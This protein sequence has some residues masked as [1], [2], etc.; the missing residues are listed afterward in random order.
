MQSIHGKKL[1]RELVK[2]MSVLGH[3]MLTSVCMYTMCSQQ[4]LL[5]GICLLPVMTLNFRHEAL[6]LQPCCQAQ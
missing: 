1:Y 5:G 4:H 3:S 2:S 6:Y